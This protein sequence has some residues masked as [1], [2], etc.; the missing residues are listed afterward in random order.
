MRDHLKENGVALDKAQFVMG[1]ELKVDPKS[2]S[3]VGE[4]E[5][6]RLL[7]REYRKPFVVPE[8]V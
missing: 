5:A 2:E 8:N 4:P 3:I 1:R 7:T 6:A